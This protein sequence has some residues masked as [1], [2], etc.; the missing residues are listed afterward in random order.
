MSRNSFSWNNSRD[1]TGFRCVRKKMSCQCYSRR[2]MLLRSANGFGAVALAA[3][4]QDRA[5][6][7]ATN[8]TSGPLTPRMGHHAAKAKSII[9]L[10]MDGGP[11]QVDTFDPKPRLARENGEPIKMH[12]PPTQFI[13]HDSPPKVLG[14]PFKF[15]RH[16]QCGTP[17]SEI[18]PHLATCVDDLAVVR[19]MVANFT[20]HA[21]ANLF[22]HTGSNSQGKP[23]VGSWVTYGLRSENHALPGYIVFKNAMSPARGP[24][25]FHTGVLPSVHHG[26]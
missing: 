15:D 3:L 25:N 6:G 11:S 4:M 8:L 24:D 9:F 12:A 10:Y 2:E 22:L 20:E 16:G 14:S 7:A 21:N 17:M 19:S 26:T 1:Q 5:F 23:S 13:P 18:F